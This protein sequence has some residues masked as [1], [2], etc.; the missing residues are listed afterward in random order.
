MNEL[1]SLSLTEIFAQ[2]SSM[3]FGNNLEMKAIRN[4]PSSV[5]EAHYLRQENDKLKKE[6]MILESE[7]R[8]SQRA[9]LPESKSSHSPFLHQESKDFSSIAMSKSRED[10]LK[11]QNDF[12]NKEILRISDLLKKVCEFSD[13]Y[14]FLELL[15]KESKYR[16]ILSSIGSTGYEATSKQRIEIE[17]NITAN[18]K[19]LNQV[20][21]DIVRK[22]GDLLQGSPQNE[23]LAK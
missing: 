9:D 3:G 13:V 23:E 4:E 10:I 19:R 2:S 15:E 11:R 7:V 8:K 22:M 5:G 17:Q 21:K 14:D 1:N 20:E 12:K 6:I 18:E 16:Y